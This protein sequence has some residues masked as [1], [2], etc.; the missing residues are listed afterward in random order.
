MHLNS[1]RIKAL[2]KK[3]KELGA[4]QA[5]VFVST[6]RNLKIDVIDQKLETDDD[7]E[8]GGTA[9]RVIKNKRMGFSF[10]AETD[11]EM[12]EEAVRSA[13]ENS[14]FAAEDEN[15]CFAEPASQA[16]K[17]ELTDK[18]IKSASLNEK[19]KLALDA[20]KSARSHD[21]RVKK[22]EKISYEDSYTITT[23][24]NSSGVMAHYEKAA[25]GLFADVIA[26]EGGQMESGSWMSYGTKFKDLA[27]ANVGGIAASRAISM[28]GAGPEKS[29][30]ASIVLS[31]LAA[32][33]LISSLVPALSAESV[34]KGKSMLRG[35]ID[36]PVASRRI[37]LIDSGVLRDGAGSCPYDDE[38]TPTKE[39]AVIREGYLK[40][41]LYDCR[42]AKKD[43]TKST[44][45]AFR[46]SFRSQ[47]DISPTNLYVAPSSKTQEELLHDLNRGFLIEN[48]MGA[49]TIN[50]ISGDF[51]IGFSGF[52][53]DKGKISGAVRSMTIAGN[54]LELLNHIEDIGSDIMFFPHAG[55]IGSPSLLVTNISVSGS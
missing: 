13:I 1:D 32:S 31:P 26:E 41:F 10:T 29:G 53:V 19:I 16:V 51:S 18:D 12:L 35:S 37:T 39:I 14:K 45:N 47:P 46:A 7:I 6:S 34:Q 4:D 8:T 52:F 44:A 48:I 20:E 55:N 36:K 17:L 28:L 11:E 40:S 43:N 50:P 22:T 2:L 23:I 24:A 15:N 5:E 54:I 9:I 38:G 3:A 30:R 33:V 21:P 27:A 25:C 49:H 42:T